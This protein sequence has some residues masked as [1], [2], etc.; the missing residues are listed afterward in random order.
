[1]SAAGPRTGRRLLA[2]LVACTCLALGGASPAAATTERAAS[3]PVSATLT[4]TKAGIGRWHGLRLRVTRAGQP[5]FAAVARGPGCRVPYCA[6]AGAALGGRSLRVVDVDGD[7]EP[8]V[9]VDLYTGGAH[10]CTVTELLRWTGTRYAVRTHDW[11]DPGYALGPAAPGAPRPFVTADARFG[12]TFAPYAD[13]PMPVV[14]LEFG[15]AGWR[16][17]TAAHPEA[18]TTDARRLAR[19]YRHRRGGRFAL[20]VLAAW[21][22]DEARLGHTAA[23][24][25]FLRAELR[26]GRLRTTPPWPGR[27]VYVRTL[28]RNLRGWGY[29]A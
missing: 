11:A 14:V 27:R 18:L 7:A 28:L 5:A 2:G 24:E 22:A 1:M 23:A 19:A 25:R 16:D 4:Y 26:A 12:Y 10:C 8:E 17:V 9:L 29:I 6:P 15:A 21:V 3:G 13:S 20:G